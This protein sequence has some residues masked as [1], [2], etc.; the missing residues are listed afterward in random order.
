ML[1]TT[2]SRKGCAR[3]AVVL[4]AVLI[5]AVTAVVG[6]PVSAEIV[7]GYFDVKDVRVAGNAST[8]VDTGISLKTGDRV[9][10]TADGKINPG[11]L[12]CNDTGPAGYQDPAPDDGWP[13]KGARQHSL[14]GK[15]N[16]QY[17]YIGTGKDWVHTGGPGKLYLYVNDWKTDDNS[18][19]F[20]A[21]IRVDRDVPLPETTITSGPSGP[22]NVNSAIFG[23]SGSS[24]EGFVSFECSIDGGGFAPCFS[25]KTL[26]GLAQGQHTFEVRAKDW[27]NRPDPTP[28]QRTWTVDTIAPDTLILSGPSGTVLDDSAR[29]EFSSEPGTTFECKLDGGVFEP[30]SSPKV[31]TSLAFG[32]HTFEVRAIDGA[33]NVDQ[34][35]ASRSWTAQQNTPPEVIFPKPVPGSKIR[36]RTPLIRA[37]VRDAETELTQGNITLKVDGIV[38]SFAYD[39]V[40]DKLLRQ[41][42]K[43]AFGTHKVSITAT[44]G[45]ANTTKTWSFKVVR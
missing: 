31:Y 42:N 17:F 10:V 8:D 9:V 11:C 30:C 39:A 24:T 20:F 22:V 29:F 36:D 3:L 37:V 44:D 35:P 23:F 12:F 40:S 41:S 33:G 7:P 43:L 34:S 6:R 16:G 1:T 32:A 19:A 13:L 15:I 5:A 18:G 14:L 45:Q 4:T 26:T 38:K 27:R 28:A 21:D 2:L 25:P